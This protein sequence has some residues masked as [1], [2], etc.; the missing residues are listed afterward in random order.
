MTDEKKP[1]KHT[2]LMCPQCKKSVAFEVNR[3]RKAL[4]FYCPAC[5]NHWSASEP[6]SKPN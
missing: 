4:I 1:L 6:G 3:L 2:G 5:G